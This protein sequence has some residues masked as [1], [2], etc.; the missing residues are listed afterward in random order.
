MRIFW[1][2]GENLHGGGRRGWEMFA[3]GEFFG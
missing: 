3:E 2:E 1:D